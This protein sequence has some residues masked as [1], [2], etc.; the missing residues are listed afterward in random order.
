LVGKIRENISV[1][2]FQRIATDHQLASYVHGGKIGVLVEF[3]GPD[4]VGRDLAMHIAATKPRA[5]DS[6]G[7]PAA[8]IEAERSVAKQKAAESGKPEN[9]ATKMVE[10]A[11][12][13]FVKEVALLSQ[14][15]V[16]NDK[17]TVAE[18]LSAQGAN[19]HHFILF[20]V[21]EGMEKKTNDFAAEVAAVAQGG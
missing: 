15:F 12:Q 9:I 8:D 18:M 3:S 1:R 10:G 17:Q 7:V 21:G 14:P 6:S 20:I 4:H 5:L 13:K 11:V 16:K 2:R 19:I